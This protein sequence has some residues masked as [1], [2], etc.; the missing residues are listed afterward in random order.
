MGIPLGLMS[1]WINLKL[2]ESIASAQGCCKSVRS[3]MGSKCQ[4]QIESKTY[5]SVSDHCCRTWGE[6]PHTLKIDML[7]SRSR[8]AVPMKNRFE[9]CNHGFWWFAAIGFFCQ[10]SPVCGMANHYWFWFRTAD[11][12]WPWQHYLQTSERSKFNAQIHPSSNIIPLQLAVDSVWR[13][14]H[15]TV[16]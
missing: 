5:H 11:K 10:F 3:W 8:C 2:C 6:G 15:V 16:T 13:S 7:W 14:S 1:H 4:I 12:L 9:N